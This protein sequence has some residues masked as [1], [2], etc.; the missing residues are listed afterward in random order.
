MEGF[1]NL[2]HSI[3]PLEKSKQNLPPLAKQ[4]ILI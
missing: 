2:L 3:G 1:E 4:S